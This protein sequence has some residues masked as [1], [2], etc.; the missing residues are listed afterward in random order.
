M[1]GLGILWP[2][3]GRGSAGGYKYYSY[4][5]RT[6]L[7]CSGVFLGFPWLYIKGLGLVITA[8]ILLPLVASKIWGG[9]KEPE[10]VVT[11]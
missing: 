8:A 4:V 2:G 3:F 6:I 5:L 11:G 7:V 1:L 10:A 9:R